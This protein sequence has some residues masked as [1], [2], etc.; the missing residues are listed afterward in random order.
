[1]KKAD[2]NL[3]KS[4]IEKYFKID[5][6]FKQFR[7]TEIIQAR[8]IFNAIAYQEYK[9]LNYI[10]RFG[11]R[12]HATI[13]KSLKSHEQFLTQ[14]QYKNDFIAIYKIYSKSNDVNNKDL[15]I[16]VLKYQLVELKKENEFF[17]QINKPKEGLFEKIEFLYN[18]SPD[19]KI[20][21]DAF[22]NINFKLYSNYFVD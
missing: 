2:L 13:L 11:K 18:E 1:M 6:I 21:L 15:D 8:C 7:K 10:G 22:C 20:K 14:S 9:N 17:K 4:I 5:D 3:L 19:F 12:T 16:F